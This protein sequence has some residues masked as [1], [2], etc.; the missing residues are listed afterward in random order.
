MILT[1]QA[2]RHWWYED[3]T[4]DATAFGRLQFSFTVAGRDQWWVHH[5]AMWLASVAYVAAGLSTTQVPDP[6]WVPLPPHS[7]RGRTRKSAAPV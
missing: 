2:A 4:V 3:P 6:A 7:N 5:R 1:R